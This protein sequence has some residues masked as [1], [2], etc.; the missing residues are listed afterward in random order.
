M[1]SK[2][3]QYEIPKY[4]NTFRLTPEY[5][6]CISLSFDSDDD[7]EIEIN[8]HKFSDCIN[9]FVL[10]ANEYI[11]KDH[12]EY[13]QYYLNGKEYGYGGV[14]GNNFKCTK[15]KD[16]YYKCENDKYKCY[17]SYDPNEIIVHKRTCLSKQEDEDLQDASF[18]YYTKET[19]N[20]KIEDYTENDVAYYIS[21]NT[22]LYGKNA[23]GR[24][25]CTE[26]KK[27]HWT[28]KNDKYICYAYGFE[29][30]P[31]EPPQFSCD[32]R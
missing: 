6:I 23:Y 18:E 5:K 31:N 14:Y 22:G 20:K 8:K 3:E 16:I 9:S 32:R 25:S 21:S 7:A 13:V 19:Y 10:H 1:K 15:D 12:S 17:A 11:Q 4:Y 24:L 28:C 26:T 30:R 29:T 2:L 27:I